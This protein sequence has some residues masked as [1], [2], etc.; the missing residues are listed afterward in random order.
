MKRV[1][2]LIRCY[3]STRRWTK[4]M[5]K[6]IQRLWNVVHSFLCATVDRVQ[7]PEFR[8][9]TWEKGEDI[10]VGQLSLANRLPHFQLFG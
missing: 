3:L 10:V 9:S 5:K 4:P 1:I 2:L 7:L 6:I 8:K